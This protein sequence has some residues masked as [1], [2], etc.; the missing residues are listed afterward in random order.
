M[1]IEA[2]WW[3]HRRLVVLVDEVLLE[4]V[5]VFVRQF[6]AV[7]LLDAVGQQAAVQADEV[8]WQLADQRGDV[9]IF[10]VGVGVVL[11]AGR[12]VRGVAVVD[13]IRVSRGLA[14][15]SVCFWR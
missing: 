14:R 15:S 13:Q 8:C 3:H 2:Q 12:R 6:L 7:H 5:Q 11:R 4:Q 9:L 10:D 1:V